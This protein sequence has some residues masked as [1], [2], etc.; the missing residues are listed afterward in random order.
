MRAPLFLLLA[1]SLFILTG[2]PNHTTSPREEGPD[3]S[4]AYYEEMTNTWDRGM[5]FFA[6]E[7]KSD[8]LRALQ[9]TLDWIKTQG[10]VKNAGISDD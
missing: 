6:D 9:A 7:R 5:E 3:L 10:S 4:E 1:S 2:C 8:S